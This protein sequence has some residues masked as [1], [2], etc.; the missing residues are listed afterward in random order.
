[1]HSFTASAQLS[2]TAQRTGGSLQFALRSFSLFV[3]S[4]VF[5][6]PK[7]GVSKLDGSKRFSTPPSLGHLVVAASASVVSFSLTRIPHHNIHLSS[8]LLNPPNP[9]KWA[10]LISSPMPVLPVSK[11]PNRPPHA[12]APALNERRDHER[13]TGRLT[14]CDFSAQQLAPHPLLCHW[15]S[16]SKVLRDMMVSFHLAP[17]E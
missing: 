14:R 15:V 1:M 9:S 2:G 13:R 16:I 7:S 6:A 4:G 17:F 11:P 10:S 8:P 12:P 3:E 5:R